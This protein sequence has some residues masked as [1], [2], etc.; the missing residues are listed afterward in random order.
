MIVLL[1]HLFLFC[2]LFSFPTIDV[3]VCKLKHT[4][5]SGV[6]SL[7]HQLQGT[8]K[9]STFLIKAALWV[10]NQVQ[11]SSLDVKR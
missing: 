5:M 8:Q 1:V 4:W 3:L 10:K 11:S 6:N 9:Q 2:F 7:V